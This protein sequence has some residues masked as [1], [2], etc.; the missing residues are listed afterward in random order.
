[1][2][3]DLA[4]LLV[5]TLQLALWLSLPVLVASLGVAAVTSLVQGAMQASDPSIG[6]APKLFAVLAVLWLSRDY[7]AERLLAFGAKVLGMMGQLG[8]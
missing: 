3:L 7:L 5:E 8:G 1:M 2:E 6:F 4:A